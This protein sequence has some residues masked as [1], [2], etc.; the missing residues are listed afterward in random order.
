MR[1]MNDA[2]ENCVGERGITEVFVP[3]IRR[4]L[5]GDDRGAMAV[6]VIEDHVIVPPEW[7]QRLI[8]EIGRGTA[9]VGGSV[10][11]AATETLLDQA[12]RMAHRA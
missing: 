5:T 7:A 12:C 8:D 11:N 3:A 4:Q 6:A 9:V 10:E 1:T 2:V